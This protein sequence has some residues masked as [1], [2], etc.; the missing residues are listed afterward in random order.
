VFFRKTQKLSQKLKKPSFV[1]GFPLVMVWFLF[2]FLWFRF[3][4]GLVF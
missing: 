3:G 1:F 4:F 2:G